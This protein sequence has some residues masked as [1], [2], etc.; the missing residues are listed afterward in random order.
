MAGM[1]V[2]VL[3]YSAL[4]SRFYVK[5]ISLAVC[6]LIHWLSLPF[7][8]ISGKIKKLLT[9]ISRTLRKIVNSFVKTLKKIVKAV[10]ILIFGHHKRAGENHVKSKKQGKP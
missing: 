5:Y 9:F 6:K 8:W 7:R 3:F 1:A 10:K 2:G 4:I